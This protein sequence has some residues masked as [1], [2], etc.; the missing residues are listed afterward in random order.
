MNSENAEDIASMMKWCVDEGDEEMNCNII[1]AVSWT[2]ITTVGLHESFNLNDSV[3]DI[4]DRIYVLFAK[5]V[6][7]R[8]G[9]TF[10][11]TYG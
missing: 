4:Y 6:N 11:S 3:A 7:S 10:G 2:I 5:T 8:F 1:L 9:A